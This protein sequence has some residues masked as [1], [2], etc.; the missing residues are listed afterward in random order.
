M[1]ISE[2]H[3][4]SKVTLLFRFSFLNRFLWQGGRV[5]SLDAICPVP[6]SNRWGETP[7][8]APLFETHGSKDIGY[9]DPT[10]NEAFEP[11]SH[12]GLV[13]MDFSD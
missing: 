7:E 4:I 3:G 6:F 9:I 10:E 1:A 12:E 11:Q 5:S 2:L 13:Q 8:T